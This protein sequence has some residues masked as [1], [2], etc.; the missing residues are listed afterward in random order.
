MLN[1]REFMNA[2]LAIVADSTDETSVAVREKANAELARLDAT[3]EK[4]RNTLTKA[5]KENEPIKAQIM[6]FGVG[7]IDMLASEVAEGVGVSTSKASALCR[8]LVEDGKMTVKDVKVKGKASCKAYT[9]II[10]HAE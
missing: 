9:L 4:R 6:E 8:A 7:K 1:T 10:E 2:I 5:Q 3:N